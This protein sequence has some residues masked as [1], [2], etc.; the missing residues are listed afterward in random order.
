[1]NRL[2]MLAS[3]LTLLSA[4]GQS[5]FAQS[6]TSSQAPVRDPQ[7]IALATNSLTAMGANAASAQL[8]SRATGVLTMHFDT[9][10]T[11]SAVFE[12][13]G[14]TETRA[15]LQQPS[16]TSIRVLSGGRGAFQNSDG[17]IR[18]LNQINTLWEHVNTIPIF[19]LLAE[20][21][22]P[23]TEVTVVSR[24][25]ANGSA[26]DVISVGWAW[27]TDPN[28]AA[29]Q[30]RLS[31]TLFFINQTSGLVDKIEYTYL[32]ELPNSTSMDVQQVFTDYRNVGGIAV[33]FHQTTLLDGRVESDL[34]LSAIQFN[35]GL[36]ESEFTVPG[37][38]Q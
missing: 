37:A 3:S 14:M 2:R 17:S 26:D 11:A 15:V 28:Q 16:G 18:Q 33:P 13:K 36:P 6:A 31:R 10:V 27:A 7:A 22:N 9:P 19:S 35:V 24:A 4:L 12:S 34:Q 8:D 25:S 32:S 1:M 38:A 23:A 5:A 21:Q 20:V 30:R 29:I